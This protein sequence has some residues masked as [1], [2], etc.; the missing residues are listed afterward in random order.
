VLILSVK[1]I[2]QLMAINRDPLILPFLI[3]PD[4]W[5]CTLGTDEDVMN[6]CVA[7]MGVGQQWS[8]A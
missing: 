6:R 3:G 7:A 1:M 5:P 2:P 8:W 4:D